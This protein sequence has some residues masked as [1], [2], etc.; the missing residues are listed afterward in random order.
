MAAVGSPGE[1]VAHASQ[2]LSEFF[3]EIE[4]AGGTILSAEDHQSITA[5]IRA[6]RG[7]LT[8]SEE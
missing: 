7:P 2:T 1:E 3:A 6:D 5:G 8:V 4:A